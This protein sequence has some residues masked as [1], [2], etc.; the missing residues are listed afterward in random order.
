M[1][2][3]NA[4]TEYVELDTVGPSFASVMNRAEEAAEKLIN[5]MKT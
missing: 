3:W 5:P 2:G 4:R 1:R